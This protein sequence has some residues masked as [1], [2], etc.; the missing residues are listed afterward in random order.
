MNSTDKIGY[1]GP[2][3]EPCPTAMAQEYILELKRMAIDL[4]KLRQKPLI[5]KA[6]TKHRKRSFWLTNSGKPRLTFLF[7]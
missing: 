6:N 5:L 7:A 2:M 1:E 4:Y 3:A